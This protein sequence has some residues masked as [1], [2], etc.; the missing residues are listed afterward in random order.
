[1]R[2][3]FVQP[4]SY[5]L[6]RERHEQLKEPPLRSGPVMVSGA[7]RELLRLI[8]LRGPKA[9]LAV[10]LAPR[11]PDSEVI[12][13]M[14]NNLVLLGDPELVRRVVEPVELLDETALS[15][16]SLPKLRA[17][18]HDVDSLSGLRIDFGG[19]SEVPVKEVLFHLL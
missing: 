6:S 14:E 9:G 2:G 12:R 10:D 11:V 4:C 7:P 18:L 3:V 1:M 17:V 8:S 13:L 5:A 15:E 19:V 16:T